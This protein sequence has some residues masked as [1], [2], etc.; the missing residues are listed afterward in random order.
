MPSTSQMAPPAADKAVEQ[1][2]FTIELDLDSLYI[3]REAQ[4]NAANLKKQGLCRLSQISREKETSVFFAVWHGEHCAAVNLRLS[5]FTH[6]RIQHQTFYIVYFWYSRCRHGPELDLVAEQVQLIVDTHYSYVGCCEYAKRYVA[7]TSRVDRNISPARRGKLVPIEEEEG[8]SCHSQAQLGFDL[9]L[10]L[11]EKHPVLKAWEYETSCSKLSRRKAACKTSKKRLHDGSSPIASAEATL[12]GSLEPQQQDH[13][14]IWSLCAATA[15]LQL[16]KEDDTETKKKSSALK[17]A[18]AGLKSAGKKAALAPLFISVF[19]VDV[20]HL[21]IHLPEAEGF[22]S[23]NPLDTSKGLWTMADQ[24]QNHGTSFQWLLRMTC[25][26]I[27][28]VL[29]NV[30]NRNVN[31]DVESQ[32][33]KKKKWERALLM[34]HRMVNHL[35][36]VGARLYDAYAG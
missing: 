9:L 14:D 21:T 32:E 8:A 5:P 10:E 4:E 22:N 30:F 11:E 6:R 17:K 34:L 18:I 20:S 12:H 2:G 27:R 19:Q 33:A 16:P 28:I 36:P 3:T 26:A 24:V 31:D 15:K 29:R 7:W 13:D 23:P 35:G 1:D 25:A